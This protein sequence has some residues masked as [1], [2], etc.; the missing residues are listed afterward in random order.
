MNDR[1]PIFPVGVTSKVDLCD[2]QHLDPCR[3]PAESLASQLWSR[4]SFYFQN[5]KELTRDETNVRTD[6]CTTVEAEDE[7][8]EPQEITCA[9]YYRVIEES[10]LVFAVPGCWFYLLFFAGYLLSWNHPSTIW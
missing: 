9:Q 3:H 7:D 2:L 6:I 5:P 8:D 4:V 10:L 1:Q